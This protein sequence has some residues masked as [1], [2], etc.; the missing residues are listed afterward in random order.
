MPTAIRGTHH[1]T[2][3]VGAA[4]EDFDFHARLLG[5]RFLKQTGLYEGKVPIYHLYYGNAEGQPG[6]VLTTFPMRQQG[7]TGRLGTDQISRLNLS[8]PQGSLG[9]WMDRLSKSGIETTAVDLYGSE[10]I[11][12][13]H[14]C[15]LP[16]ALVA[17]GY[18][19]PA[20]SWGQNGVAAEHAILGTH[21]ITVNAST[22]DAMITYLETGIG[23]V[24]DGADEAGRRWRLGA[25]PGRVGYI[26]LV[27]D[28]DSP[29]ATRFVGEGTVHHCAWDAGDS[30]V[31]LAVKGRLEDQGY[32]GWLGPVD[33]GYFV[34]VYNRTPSGALFEYAWSKPKSW[35]IDEP[36]DQLGQTFKVPP[37]LAEQRDTILEYLEPL[38]VGAP[39]GGRVHA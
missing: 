33:R 13:A 34:S 6:T 20:R 10:R 2:S 16:Y 26:E 11:H 14:P 28:R 5:L 15:G 35:A 38:D 23:A 9:F 37:N 27:E 18:G 3:G 25:D 8:I 24:E 1:Y 29:P 4:Q 7:I 30:E 21:G 19:D 22:L 31:Q 39:L 36:P 12:L 17:D 32:E